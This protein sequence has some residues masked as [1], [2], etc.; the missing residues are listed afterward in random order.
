MWKAL[1][2]VVMPPVSLYLLVAV[3][4]ALRALTS[5]AWIRRTAGGL[6]AIGALGTVALSL[7][8]VAWW[9]LSA[10]QTDASIPADATVIDAEAIV[11]L[12]ADVDCDPPEYGPDQPGALSL[13]RCRYGA[14]LARRTGLPLGI[15]GGV[16][17]PD[18][19]PVSHV[20]RDFVSDELGVPVAWTEDRATTTRGNARG[21]ADLLRAQGVSRVAL[22]THAW[23]MPRAREEFERAGLSVLEAPTIRATVPSRWWRG[24][25]PRGRSVRDSCWAIHEMLGRAWYAWTATP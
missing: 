19:R 5:R 24:W 4:L 9:L 21:S 8:W 7:P 17:R 22:V 15:T 11:V 20:L 13:Q 6:A 1:E 3:G 14:Q 2:T 25:I 23:H 10:L 18:R 16:L 12:A